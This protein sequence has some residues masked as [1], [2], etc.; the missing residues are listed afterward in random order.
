M[1]T[2]VR[3][4]ALAGAILA[5]SAVMLAS[6]GAHLIQMNGLA[7]VWRTASIIHMFNAASLLGLAALL[8]SRESA[9]L[10]WGAWVIATGTILFS[11]TIYTHVIIGFQ[12][13]GLTPVGG[14]IMML[15]WAL[16][17]IAFLRKS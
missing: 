1:N 7:E 5:L 17:V 14:L 9:V 4:I 12:V 13:P 6:L 15:G 2:S 3:N 10:K 11:G 16:V 8:T